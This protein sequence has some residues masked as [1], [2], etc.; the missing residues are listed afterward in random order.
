L[1]LL[2]DEGVDRPI[3]SHLREQGHSVVYIA[4]L[5]SGASDE[6]VLAK[7]AQ[8]N[9]PLLTTDKDFGELVFRQHLTS[10]GVILLR[11]AGLTQEAKTT[12]VAAALRDHAAELLGAFTVISPGVVRIRRASAG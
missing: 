6:F 2:C 7:A 9:A 10:A 4:E 1:N 8:L 3:V 5:E 12:V 11:L